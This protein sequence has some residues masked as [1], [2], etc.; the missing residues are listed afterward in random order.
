MR[1]RNASGCCGGFGVVAATPKKSHC[2]PNEAPGSREQAII[3]EFNGLMMGHPPTGLTPGLVDCRR[4]VK[5]GP[6]TPCNNANYALVQQQLDSLC[7]S[8][9]QERAHGVV[10][11]ENVSADTPANLQVIQDPS[12]PLIPIAPE[13]RDGGP[14]LTVATE[15]SATGG[16]KTLYYVGGA[17][18]LG[19]VL[20]MVLTRK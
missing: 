9:A 3:N 11:S 5:F 1:H 13:L 4:T 2:Y 17:V 16:N 15:A 20:A 14:P 10:R 18:V 19:V 8:I 12:T 7:R 6:Q